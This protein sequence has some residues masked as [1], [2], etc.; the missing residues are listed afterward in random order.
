MNI[1]I[2]VKCCFVLV[3][4]LYIDCSYCYIDC[5][6]RCFCTNF[7]HCTVPQSYDCKSVIFSL[8]TM[9]TFITVELTPTTINQIQFN[10]I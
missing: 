8:T 1:I 6:C 4:N 7:T 9:N 10:L 2:I 3:A 5:C